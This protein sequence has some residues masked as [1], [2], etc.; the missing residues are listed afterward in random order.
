MHVTLS[1]LTD[2][3]EGEEGVAVMRTVQADQ[4]V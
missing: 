3:R 2:K 1:E 4:Q